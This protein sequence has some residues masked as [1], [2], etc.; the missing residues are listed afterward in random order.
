[1]VADG[2]DFLRVKVGDFVV[3]EEDLPFP[4]EGKGDYWV[5]QILHVIGGSRKSSLNSIFQVV[6]IDTG[7]I[8]EINADLVIRILQRS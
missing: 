6:N 2:A 4:K 1:M 8:K 3:I 7:C 5:G